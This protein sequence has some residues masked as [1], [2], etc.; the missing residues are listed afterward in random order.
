MAS[1]EELCM[2]ERLAKVCRAM[3]VYPY[4]KFTLMDSI[5]ALAC[6]RSEQ[7]ATNISIE[8]PT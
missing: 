8:K 1:F 4:S 7:P 5:V 2:K 3:P 6:A